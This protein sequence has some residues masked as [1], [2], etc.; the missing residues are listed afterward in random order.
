MHK[1]KAPSN[2]NVGTSKDEHVSYY[3]SAISAYKV[4]DLIYSS[5]IL[6]QKMLGFNRSIILIVQNIL[7]LEFMSL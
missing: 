7:V 5:Q 1:E 3:D 6:D 2:T 4:K